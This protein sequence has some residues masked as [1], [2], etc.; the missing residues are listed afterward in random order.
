MANI[1]FSKWGIIGIMFLIVFLSGGFGLFDIIQ[2][3]P[4][5]I[6]FGIVALVVFAGGKSG[7]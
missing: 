2:D 7:N 6:V 4:I 3:N 5:I 1:F